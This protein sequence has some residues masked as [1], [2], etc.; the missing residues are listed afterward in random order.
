MLRFIEGIGMAMH[1]TTAYTVAAKL[2]PDSTGSAIV[3][4]ICTMLPDKLGQYTYTGTYCNKYSYT[5][6]A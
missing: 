6:N 2:Y 5:I 1:I 4:E 3:S